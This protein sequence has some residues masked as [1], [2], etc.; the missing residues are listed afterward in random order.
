MII[1]NRLKRE[2]DGI[3]K[4]YRTLVINIVKNLKEE[5]EHN[6]GKM[7]SSK[8]RNDNPKQSSSYGRNWNLK[9]K[10]T[11]TEHLKI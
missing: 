8:Y 9:N 5:N 6:E 1:R 2:N 10:Q 7:R 4:D 11:K 3:S